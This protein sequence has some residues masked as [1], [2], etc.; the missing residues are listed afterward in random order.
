M[1]WRLNSIRIFVDKRTGGGRQ[2]LPLLQPLAGGTVVQIYGYESDTTQIGG[3]VVG[4]GDMSSLLLTKQTGLTYQLTSP[5]GVV[6]DFYVKDV[7][8][9]RIQVVMQTMRPDLSCYAPVYNVDLDLI[10][11]SGYFLIP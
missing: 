3:L 5:E 8:Y 10:P 9:S 2:T 1:D 7:K 11:A 4:S 6:G